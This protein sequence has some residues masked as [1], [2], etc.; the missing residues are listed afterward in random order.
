M[1]KNKIPEKYLPI[2]TVVRLYGDKRMIM[3]SGFS[4]K[5]IKNDDKVWDYCGCVYPLGF[6][7]SERSLIFNHSQIIKVYFLGYQNEEEKIFKEK[8]KLIN[9]PRIKNNNKKES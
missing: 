8:L 1:E 9:M 7:S 3:I 2:G 5:N 4:V 6:Y